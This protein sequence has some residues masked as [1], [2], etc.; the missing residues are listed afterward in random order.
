[1]F[2]IGTKA[3]GENPWTEAELL[4]PHEVEYPERRNYSAQT[5]LD[6]SVVVQRSLR[7]SRPRK[8]YWLTLPMNNGTYEAH[9]EQLREL[10]YRYRTDAGLYPYVGVWEDGTSA[11]G[12]DRMDGP[13]KLLTRVKVLQ[14]TRVARPNYFPETFIE[15]WIDDPTWTEF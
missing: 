1:M 7:D 10:D 13:S 8:W 2:L 11:G 12:L 14:V 3:S 4:A 5:T 6:G 9:W 15:F